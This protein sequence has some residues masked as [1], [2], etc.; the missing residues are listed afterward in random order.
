MRARSRS[1]VP[2]ASRRSGERRP[3]E[4]LPQVPDVNMEMNKRYV[5]ALKELSDNLDS[6][7]SRSQY[8]YDQIALTMESLHKTFAFVHGMNALF[9]NNYNFFCN[10]RM[11]YVIFLK[12]SVVLSIIQFQKFVQI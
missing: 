8:T 1:P 12:I 3:R 10:F 9:L 4:N 2:G 5:L 7:I 11:L 6:A